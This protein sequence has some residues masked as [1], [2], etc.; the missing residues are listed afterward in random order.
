[1]RTA[2]SP[3]FYDLEKFPEFKKL[4]SQYPVILEEFDASDFW[5]TWLGDAPNLSKTAFDFAEGDWFACP[6]YFKAKTAAKEFSFAEDELKCSQYQTLLSIKFPKITR[7]IK[8]I[9]HARWAGFSK[10]APHAKLLP[11]VHKPMN[12]LIFHLGLIIPPNKSAGLRVDNH[13]H[14][15]EKPGDA[16]IFDDTFTHTA[17]NDSDQERVIFYVKFSVSD[18]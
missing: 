2:E 12:V 8:K 10:L 17:W 16:I 9:P 3:R 14:I 5:I 1:M 18:Q 4:V 15:W 7:L 11:H 6:V 13:L